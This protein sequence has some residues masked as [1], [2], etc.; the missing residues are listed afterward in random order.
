M[1]HLARKGRR[2]IVGLDI[3]TSSVV[4]VIKDMDN[5]ANI[6]GIGECPS[7]G[8]RKGVVIDID[9]AAQSIKPAVEGA[10]QM[11]G[12]N[13]TAV[14]AGFSGAGVKV[15]ANRVGIALGKGRRITEDDIKRV[16]KNVRVVELPAGKEVLNI[17]PVDFSVDGISGIKKP[18]GK[19][20]S[21]LEIRACLL[22][23][24][25]FL[26]EQLAACIDKAGYK[27]VG[28][29]ANA[30]VLRELLTTAE[31][32]LGTAIVDIGGG[33]TGI[34]VYNR[35]FLTGME[36]LPVGGEHISS[37]L[38]I[39]LR[40]TLSEAE[41]LKR[42]IGVPDQAA[43][44]S[45]KFLELSRVGGTGTN[46]VAL[47]TAAEIIDSRLQ[48]ILDLIEQSIIALSNNGLLAGGV[49]LTGGQ[50]NM[51]GFVQLVSERMKMPVRAGA[52]DIS[53]I[54]GNFSPDPAWSVGVGIIKHVSRSSMVTESSTRMAVGSKGN[55]KS[56]FFGLF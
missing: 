25:S 24:D 47:K 13:V 20:G 9:A 50:A 7:L 23:V 17:V 5:P 21:H 36:V 31:T 34:S 40:T 18:V 39:G 19:F 51:K 53:G 52:F 33:T 8:I 15:V 2:L 27:V 37:D 29:S 26:I 28:I 43:L 11:A 32:E 55:V 10:Q 35:G 30:L 54:S 42:Q 16:I 45:V 3:G 14:F 41:E 56:K 6:A 48:E 38:A 1:P 22:I 44:N 4:A 12:A 49:V 46:R